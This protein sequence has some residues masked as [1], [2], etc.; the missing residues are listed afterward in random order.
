MTGTRGDHGEDASGRPALGGLLGRP[1]PAPLP[2]PIAA[3]G[4]GPD[5]ERRARRGAKTDLWT[6]SIR[7][8]EIL[9]PLL[10]ALALLFAGLATPPKS[11][12]FFERA[13]G[14]HPRTEYHGGALELSL[15]LVLF[16]FAFAAA[17]L[18]LR[19][20]RLR[21]PG[22]RFSPSL[23]VVMLCSSLTILILALR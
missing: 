11:Y 12:R 13:F 8:C 14:D 16:A 23:I 19:T 22:D 6:R 10:A 20:A 17:G 21:R 2:R 4:P 9:G 18:L 3:R 1:A 7:A 5:E 15:G